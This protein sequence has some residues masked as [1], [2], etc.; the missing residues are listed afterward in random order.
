MA[1]DAENL[2]TIKS[3][4]LAELAAESANPKPSYLIDGQSVQW[5]AYRNSLL[6]KVAE[7]DK[8]I[9]ATTPF[10]VASRAFS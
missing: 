8:M 3:N 5:T 4:Y 2:A 1:T 6:Q 7:I 9:A 10:E